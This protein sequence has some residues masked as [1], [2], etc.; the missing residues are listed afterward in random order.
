MVALKDGPLQMLSDSSKHHEGQAAQARVGYADE[1]LS[2]SSGQMGFCTG[3]FVRHKG[4]C[5]HPGFFPL[6]SNTQP[7]PTRDRLS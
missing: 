7:T 5:C 1:L 3:P 2:P 6:A 4:C